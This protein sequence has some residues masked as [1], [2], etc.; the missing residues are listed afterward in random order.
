M[1]EL[2]KSLTD[3]MVQAILGVC[4]PVKIILFGSYANNR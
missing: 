1:I 2:T 4:K 3:Q